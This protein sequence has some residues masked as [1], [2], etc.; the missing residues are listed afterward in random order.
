[1]AAV[2]VIFNGTQIARGMV[3]TSL[4][5]GRGDECDLRV[6]DGDISRRHCR[7]EREPEGYF[8]VDLGSRNGTVLDGARIN[9]HLLRDGDVLRIGNHTLQFESGAAAP[10]TLDDEV[11][12]M[13]NDIAPSPSGELEAVGSAIRGPDAMMEDEGGEVATAVVAAPSVEPTKPKV[14]RVRA[15]LWEAA[16]S[17]TA[18]SR[19]SPRSMPSG[20]SSGRPPLLAR[21]GLLGRQASAIQQVSWARRRIPLPATIAAAVAATIIIYLLAWGLP[22]NGPRFD[23]NKPLQH[24]RHARSA[25]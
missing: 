25:D 23:P 9:R 11:L 24:A 14:E 18:P 8:I 15:S 17:T 3:N 6:A 21:L 4:V 5:I 13:L 12:E 2:R 19:P 1:M 10:R 20:E 7:I 16:I 22:N